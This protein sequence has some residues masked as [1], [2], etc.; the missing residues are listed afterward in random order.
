[1][2]VRLLESPSNIYKH[3]HTHVHLRYSLRTWWCNRMICHWSTDPWDTI[4]NE[5]IV[6]SWFGHRSLRPLDRSIVG[7]DDSLGIWWNTPQC[8][9]SRRFRY[10]GRVAPVAVVAVPHG[11]SCGWMMMMWWY[12]CCCC[13]RCQ[14]CK[15]LLLWPSNKWRWGA[16]MSRRSGSW[17]WMLLKMEWGWMVVGCVAY[18]ATAIPLPGTNRN[19]NLKIGWMDGWMTTLSTVVKV[20]GIVVIVVVGVCRVANRVP[21]RKCCGSSG[22]RESVASRVHVSTGW[23]FIHIYTY[24]DW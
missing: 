18:V 4:G 11:M 15:I 21:R 5:P 8:R 16:V 2:S 17:W 13:Y 9:N 19:W 14:R 3:Y 22:R 12:C 20:D 24:Q 1:M 7:R 23:I 10:R 6:W